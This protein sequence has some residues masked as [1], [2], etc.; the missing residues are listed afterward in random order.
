MTV[1]LTCRTNVVDVRFRL[2]SPPPNFHDLAG[3]G[4]VRAEL[5]QHYAEQVLKVNSQRRPGNI[6]LFPFVS[7]PTSSQIFTRTNIKKFLSFILP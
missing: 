2:G 4:S 6:R 3:S 1:P 5:R 7:S